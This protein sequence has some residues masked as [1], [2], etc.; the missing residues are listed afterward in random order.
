MYNVYNGQIVN[1][2]M[3][4]NATI[5]IPYVPVA[6][7]LGFTASLNQSFL[8]STPFLNLTFTSFTVEMWIYLSSTS[9]DDRGIFSQC[10]CVWC[11]NQCLNIIVRSN[12]VYAGF[13]LND[14]TSSVTLVANRWYHVAFVYNYQAYQ[15]Q[16]YID[17]V[18]NR[19]KSNA[20]PYQGQNGTIRIG[21]AQLSSSMSFF[22]GYIDT[23]SVVTRAKSSSE[24][25]D[26]GTLLAYYSFDIPSSSTDDGPNGINGTAVNTIIIEGR[27]NQAMRFTGI[28]SSFQV[29]G[30]HRFGY[31]MM[32]NRPYSIALWINPTSVI[33]SAFFQVSTNQSSGACANIFGFISNPGST[34]QLLAQAYVSNWQTV[35][36]F[37]P[38]IST[39]TWTHI[40]LTFS[41]TNGYILYVNGI[42]FGS[43]GTLTAG[44]SSHMVWLYLGNA[45]NCFSG[46][47]VNTT[48][49]GAIDEVY[50]YTRELSRTDIINLAN[51]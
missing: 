48:Y 28:L 24:I 46:Y 11:A 38:F 14:I 13:T 34:G 33:S 47:F 1:G 3:Y 17:G 44:I 51:P 20:Q 31:V 37:G 26:D 8:V 23:V 29:F 10:F 4:S 27:V 50:L 42:S 22:D 6:R 9:T 19:T 16:L 41:P 49:Q 2:A 21:T 12:T 7:A 43:T 5:G 15:Q 40:S 36:I 32:F 39:N 45:I 25:L 30:I 35:T 18:Q